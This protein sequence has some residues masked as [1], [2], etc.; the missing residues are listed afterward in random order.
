MHR[1]EKEEKK[2]KKDLF[3]MLLIRG[4]SNFS[5]KS[6]MKTLPDS[7]KLSNARWQNYKPSDLWGC[8]NP[9]QIY[10]LPAVSH[11]N[12]SQSACCSDW[13]QMIYNYSMFNL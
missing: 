8:G 13:C 6:Q 5:L 7:F 3:L 10:F 4:I 1:L 11:L 9:F 12:I 2:K